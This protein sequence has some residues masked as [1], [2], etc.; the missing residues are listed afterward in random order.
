[1]TRTKIFAAVAAV[2]SIIVVAASASFRDTRHASPQPSTHTAGQSGS[3]DHFN[4]DNFNKDNFSKDNSSKDNS[5]Q[6]DF[7]ARFAVSHKGDRLPSPGALPLAAADARA[8]APPPVAPPPEPRLQT[9][10][11]DDLRQADEE[12]HRHRDICARGRTW[13]TQ[14]NHRYWRCKL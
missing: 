1:M 13:F 9:A 3:Q 14:N 2:C 6:A 11:E 7:D 5:S 8:E 10:T 12:H 4:K